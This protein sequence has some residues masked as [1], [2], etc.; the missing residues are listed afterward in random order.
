MSFSLIF[1][2]HIGYLF[3]IK[4]ILLMA[5]DSFQTNWHQKILKNQNFRK[6]SKISKILGK[7]AKNIFFCK[8]ILTFL[9]YLLVLCFLDNFRKKNFS[10]RTIFSFLLYSPY[11]S[12]RACRFSLKSHKSRIFYPISIKFCMCVP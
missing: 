10:I 3:F 4:T 9:L 7:K 5:F 8:N 12:G 2:G 6:F 1:C 11:R